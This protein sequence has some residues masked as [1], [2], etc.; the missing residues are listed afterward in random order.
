M[1]S[2][3]A[4]SVLI[5]TYYWPPSGGSG[6]QRW[7]KFA[8]YLDLAG[9]QVFVLTPE[10]PAFSVKD[11][12]LLRDVPANVE[13]LKLPIWEPYD[14]FYKLASIFGKGKP[15][16]SDFITTGKKSFFQQVTTW[17]R[18][19]LL[20]PDGRVFWVKPAVTFLQ[21]IIKSNGISK[22]ITTGPPHSI[23]LIGRR[24]KKS[25]PA[26]KW[27]ADF[28]DPWSE[29]DLL[30]TL[31][32]AGWARARHKK[33]ERTVLTSADKVVTIA[34][35]HVRRL[36]ALSGR[37][38][39][40]ITNGFDHDDFAGIVRSRS[41]QFTIRHTGNVDELRDPRPFM[42]AVRRLCEQRPD[43]RASLAIDFI[44]NVNS[45][46]RKEVI[47]EPVLAQITTFTPALP[48][49]EL[50]NR[51]GKTDLQL[52]VLAHTAIAPGNLPGKFFEYLASGAPIL[53]VGPADGDAAA[54]LR[55]TSTGRI[56][57]RSDE[58]GMIKMILEHLEAW[59]SGGVA[60]T[61]NV[62]AF[63]RKNLTQQL[64]ALLESL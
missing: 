27:I 28:R 38:V 34:P 44:G 11:P 18:G 51:Y 52:L 20:I 47:E 15:A 59:K 64:I 50:L 8:K 6:V 55:E 13:V 35:F 42:R 36:E 32:L 3:R 31:S 54:I 30:D 53:G 60:R 19:N 46:F 21:D 45:A 29:W 57:E 39:S 23:H 10:Q 33:L 41:S 49:K 12:S 43:L 14:L 24:L 25:N 63:T 7:L 48:H 5:I 4:K 37:Q 58:D 40:L 16:P 1:Q 9:W 62:S 2:P 22:I 26:L 17:L 56:F 61:G